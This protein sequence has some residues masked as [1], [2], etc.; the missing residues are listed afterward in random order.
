MCTQILS[1]GWEQAS[2]SM[3]PQASLRPGCCGSFQLYIPCLQFKTKTKCRYKHFTCVYNSAATSSECRVVQFLG[4]LASSLSA[5][6]V[7]P[8]VW[9][10]TISHLDF[11]T[12]LIN[13]TLIFTSPIY[14]T[15][16]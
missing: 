15:N 2:R 4:F 8:S 16:V 14:P 7:S 13:P 11:C 12:S 1:N 5:T 3:F 10:L 9:V 6:S